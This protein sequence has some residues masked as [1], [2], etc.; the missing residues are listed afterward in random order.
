M[1]EAGRYVAPNYLGT[2]ISSFHIRADRLGRASDLL[3]F[4]RIE[5]REKLR[6]WEEQTEERRLRLEEKK[7]ILRKMENPPVFPDARKR[8][9]R[10]KKSKRPR[11]AKGNFS[12]FEQSLATYLP[13]D[14]QL[15]PYLPT[16][17][18]IVR[19]REGNCPFDRP[20]DGSPALPRCRFSF[21]RKP[22]KRFAGY[23]SRDA[24]K[25]KLICESTRSS[26]A[27]F[28]WI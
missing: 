18:E 16:P 3:E 13:G 14:G 17:N 12:E 8:G 23:C 4:A 6:I 2:P 19:Q 15:L 7:G 22:G 25:P 27:C 1:G 28:V 24:T 26:G 20:R 21:Q 10:G 11:S 9:K 5:Y